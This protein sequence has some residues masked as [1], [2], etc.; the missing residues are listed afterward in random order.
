M[1]SSYCSYSFPFNSSF[2][3]NILYSIFPSVSGSSFGSL[4]SCSSLPGHFRV[5]L[6]PHSYKIYSF[7]DQHIRN[8]SNHN[9][10]WFYRMA[11]L[12]N[13]KYFYW[14]V[15][16]QLSYKSMVSLTLRIEY[17]S[18]GNKIAML[19]VCLCLSTVC[20][21]QQLMVYHFLDHTEIKTHIKREP[22]KGQAMI[23]TRVQS[24]QL[25][26]F[27]SIFYRNRNNTAS[28]YGKTF[29]KDNSVQLK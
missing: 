2:L 1:V 19:T 27:T 28:Q 5:P 22:W 18:Y 21:P 24:E 9:W 20:L 23:I 11:P 15:I 29:R 10:Y 4:L 16:T 25:M 14:K 13:K 6:I 8:I 7:N 3:Q 17:Y 26:A 12:L